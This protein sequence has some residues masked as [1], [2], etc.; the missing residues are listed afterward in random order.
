MSS[1]KS[2]PPGLQAYEKACRLCFE[3]DMPEQDM[4]DAV[5]IKNELG[6]LVSL[7]RKITKEARKSG[8]T[9]ITELIEKH[10]KKK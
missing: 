7:I 8:D 3:S 5:Q 4:V 10:K 6:S 2:V 9:T 1:K